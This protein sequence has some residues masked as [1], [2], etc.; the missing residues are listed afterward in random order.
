MFQSMLNG[1]VAM[2][3]LACALFFL[4][5]WRQ[6]HD[7]LFAFFALSFAVLGVNSVVAGLIDVQ[8]ERRY[9]IYVARL[10]AFLIILY[11]IWDKNRASRRG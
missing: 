5:F 2:A 1:A 10:V 8:D 9:Y 3:W 6:S 11:A 7:R 4:R